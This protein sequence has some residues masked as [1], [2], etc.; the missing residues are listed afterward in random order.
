LS[1]D[2]H[3][4][5]LGPSQDIARSETIQPGR[6]RVERLRFHVHVNPRVG[7]DRPTIADA[8]IGVDE[9]VSNPLIPIRLLCRCPNRH[10]PDIALIDPR[11]LEPFQIVQFSIAVVLIAVAAGLQPGGAARPARLVK[12]LRS[13]RA[14]R[15]RDAA[16]DLPPGCPRAA[17][18][19]DPVDFIA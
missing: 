3:D 4:D 14:G 9:P 7:D 19:E 1:P 12:A 16:K 11:W 5:A 13:R 17:A 10:V 6:A 15:S 2:R 8:P 18:I